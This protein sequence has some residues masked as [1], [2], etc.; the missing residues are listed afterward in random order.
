[1][2]QRALMKLIDFPL[3]SYDVGETCIKFIRRVAT[4]WQLTVVVV[5]ILQV[6]PCLTAAAQLNSSLFDYPKSLL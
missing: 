4:R 5:Y 6:S 2:P 3:P 1:M